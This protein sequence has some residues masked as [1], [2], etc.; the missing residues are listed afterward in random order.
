MKMNKTK[1]RRSL[2]SLICAFAAIT[3]SMTAAAAGTGSFE[4]GSFIQPEINPVDRNTNANWAN[5]AAAG[6]DT[7]AV[8]G[9]GGAYSSTLNKTDNESGIANS[10]SNNVKLL[11]TDSGVYGHP[12]YTAADYA[13]LNS[14]LTPYVNDARVS[15][16]SLMDEPQQFQFEGFANTYKYIQSLKPS[17]QTYMNFYDIGYSIPGKLALSNSKANDN[18]SY[19]SSTNSIGQTFKI[20]ANVTYLDGIEMLIDS[21]QWSPS[22]SLTLKVW[23]NTAKTTL[24]GQAALSG[25]I[26]PSVGYNYPYFSVHTSVTPGTTYYME[27]T[28]NGGGDNSVGWVVRSTTDA[29][30]D[31]S[32]YEAGVAKPYDF[33]FRAY[34]TRTNIGTAFENQWDDWLTMSGADY[35]LH[36]SYPFKAGNGVPYDNPDFFSAS[37]I[38]RDRGLAHDVPYGGFLQSIHIKNP[39]TGL[40]TYRDPNMNMLRWNV[41]SYLTYGYKKM[42]WFSYW[43]PRDNNYEAYSDTPVNLD[44]TKL[45]KYAQIQTLDAEMKNLSG[46]L[47]NLTSRKVYHTGSSI[48]SGTTAL[49]STFFV[50]PSDL[51]QP[52]I[53]GHFTNP[54]GRSYIMLTN[55]D[56]N[57]SRSLDFNFSSKPSALSEISKT[58]GTEGSL[59]QGTYNA[60][61]GV[62]NMTLLPGEGRLIALPTG[63]QP[64]TNLAANATVTATSSYEITRDGFALNRINDDLRNSANRSYGWSSSSNTSANH[65]ESVTF[66]LGA[67]KTVSEV[68]L[69][70]RNDTP[71]HIGTGFPLNFTIQVAANA[72]GPWTTVT[73]KTSYALSGNYVQPFTFSPQTARYVKVEGTNLRQITDES[74]QPYRMQLAEVEIYG[75]NQPQPNLLANPDFQTGLLGPWSTEWHPNNGGVEVNYPHDTM[76]DAYLWPTTSGDVALYQTFTAPTTKS[77][78][79]TAYCSTNITNSNV[80]LGVDVGS[81]L[82]E[83]KTISPN[84]GYAPYTITFN[85]AAGQTVKLWYYGN[86]AGGWATI[87]DVMLN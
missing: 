17:W 52:M 29:Y 30:T 59:V 14:V 22:E 51:T 25:P 2:L 84:I 70:P 40:D 63:F 10:S 6:I 46:T 73:T 42:Y 81:A 79:L 8:H 58:T 47:K 31:G 61:T 74:G 72:A 5:I 44:G 13:A 11:V 38:V 69:Y 77:Y 64:Y 20:P 54:S 82:V 36:D 85:A 48:P 37:E 71:G 32:G 66:D 1:F 57:N 27:L 28:H 43:R 7:V 68:D 45:I 34:T 9:L 83:Q 35:I 50:K 12:S 55:R 4:I 60:T 62:L 39:D 78:T 53:I 15:G 87:D 49:P 23:N 41:Y 76:N 33:F 3:N 24:L 19:V 65:T 67:S 16:I 56:Y 75:S 18:G 86:A 21:N 26:K 80:R